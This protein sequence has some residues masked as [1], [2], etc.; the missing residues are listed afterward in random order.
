M[1]FDYRKYLSPATTKGRKGV[2]QHEQSVR[3]LVR[4]E[5]N[6]DEALKCLRLA[7]KYLAEANEL[8]AERFA[9]KSMNMFP[10]ERAKG[11]SILCMSMQ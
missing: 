1:A 10:N 3:Q 8:K 6:R 2:Q 5:S 9:Q 7:E 11:E 4:M